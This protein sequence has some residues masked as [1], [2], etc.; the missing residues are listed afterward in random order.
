MEWKDKK[1]TQGRPVAHADGVYLEQFF[2]ATRC[3]SKQSFSQFGNN[4]K[5]R[6][7]L[8]RKS[9]KGERD[10]TRERV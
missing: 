7:L 10:E 6:K 3:V 8:R 5:K 2:K 4:D 9:F 1:Q